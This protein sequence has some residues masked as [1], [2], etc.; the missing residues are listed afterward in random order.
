MEGSLNNCMGNQNDC[1]MN[2]VNSEF[3]NEKNTILQIK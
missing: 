2:G 3:L 1:Q